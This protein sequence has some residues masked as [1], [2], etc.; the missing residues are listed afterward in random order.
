MVSS[1]PQNNP[2]ARHPVNPAASREARQ[3]LELVYSVS[4]HKVL[5]GQHNYPSKIDGYS[6]MIAEE[7]KAWPAIFGQ[8]FGFS[9]RGTLD[10]YTLRQE[11]INTCIE[12]H[13]AG[14]IITLMWHAVRPV[15]DEPVTFKESVQGELTDRQWKDLV[16]PGT[17]IHERWKAQVD[18]VAWHLRQ[19]Q[20]ENIPVLWR[21]YHEMNGGWFWWGHKEGP[22]GY[23]KLWRM[24]YDRLVNFHHLD[25]LLWVW[26]ANELGIGKKAY[27]LYF[28]GHDVVD[29]LATDVYHGKYAKKDY[30]SL[31]K[32]ADGKPVAIGEC[33]PL[34]TA[35]LFGK[36]PQWAWFMAWSEFPWDHNTREDRDAVYAI[37]RLLTREDAPYDW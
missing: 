37:P 35:E 13:K 31:L 16:T 8:D 32:L 23:V 4:G 18:V 33:G 30:T 34:P 15:E 26:N 29:I 3:L 6:R 25:N 21:P 7:Q 12:Q 17:E 19:L 20:D 28:P 1:A 14:A 22:E 10:D 9:P 36:Q 5:S 27:D 2:E 11:I 24:L